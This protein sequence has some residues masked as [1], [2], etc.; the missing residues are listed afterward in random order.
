MRPGSMIGAAALA[1]LLL[2][3][4]GGAP[5]GGAGT[6]GASRPAPSTAG[7]TSAS[8]PATAQTATP[9]A[10]GPI[11]RGT[12]FT[13]TLPAKAKLDAGTV[14]WT[15]GFHIGWKLQGQVVEHPCPDCDPDGAAGNTAAERDFYAKGDVDAYPSFHERRLPD[16]SVAGQTMYHVTGQQNG[17]RNDHYG[18]VYGGRDVHIVLESNLNAA[19]WSAIKPIV[20]ELLAGFRFTGA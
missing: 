7:T 8:A 16:V 12:V 14:E 3:G 4:C 20:E 11:L 6:D 13:L 2:G 17:V 15:H 1:V 18:A 5:D 19:P 9:S 10:A